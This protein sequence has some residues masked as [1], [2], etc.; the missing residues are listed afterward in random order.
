M[1][2]EFELS[3][4]LADLAAT[5]G[6]SP[7]EL[8][9]PEVYEL[10]S[11]YWP[12]GRLISWVEDWVCN[13]SPLNGTVFDYMCGTGLLLSRLRLR[14]PD[15]SLGGCDIHTPFVD[16]ASRRHHL[17]IHQGDAL[18]APPAKNVDVYVCTAGLHHLEFDKQVLFL[19]K[20]ARECRP[21]CKLIIGEETIAD[22]NN[23][24]SRRLA[25]THFASEVL[26]YGINS[27]WPDEQID[28]CLMMMRNDILLK[29]EF[30]RS[31]SEWRKII[32]E[33][34]HIV[35]F[36]EIWTTAHGGDCVYMCHPR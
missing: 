13:H 4:E 11:E 15:L 22:S 19:E 31:S 30:K 23:E 9:P 10:E 36:E 20:L 21:G 32:G 28:A 17:R 33:K 16:Y 26:E 27:D 1:C 29:G 34:F 3:K 7:A 24:R 25:A 6:V 5:D 35:E 12:W 2:E 8:P 14:R 18:H